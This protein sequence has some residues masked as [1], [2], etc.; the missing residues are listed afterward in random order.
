MK[1][2][3]S[4]LLICLCNFGFA[5]KG[6]I[7]VI[8]SDFILSKM[9]EYEEANKELKKRDAEWQQ[10]IESKK[11]EIK[12]LKDQLNV[13]RPLLTQQI[14][15][16]KEEDIAIIEKELLNFQNEK[17]NSKDGSYFRQKLDLAKPLQDQITSIV[18]EIAEKK[19][20]TMVVDKAVSSETALMYV[21][22]SDE[23]SD[24]VIRKLELAR[25]KTKLSKK[26]IEQIE[27]AER[28]ADIKDR[29]RSKRDELAERQR[30]LEEEKEEALAALRST[31]NSQPVPT[32]SPEEKRKREQLEKVEK[33]KEE[34]ER[35]RQEKLQ[36]IE[37][38]K[39]EIVQKQEEAR[40]QREKAK[41]N[42]LSNIASKENAKQNPQAQLSERAQ[43]IK[44]QQEQRKQEALRKKEQLIAERTKLIEERKQKLEEEKQKRLKEIEERKKQAQNKK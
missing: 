33:A 3:A 16:E 28:Q 40:I 36:E 26:E 4:I 27:I 1:K 23:I 24:Q 39:A 18:N 35:I 8:D 13:E 14:I 41:E 15:E 37:K 6:K 43:Q 7:A 10:L 5:Q 32:E 12:D 42:A 11:K 30:L 19:R 38:R 31:S 9:P 34:R 22:K 20:Y 44:A 25:N 21:N 29:Q 17:Y 2:I